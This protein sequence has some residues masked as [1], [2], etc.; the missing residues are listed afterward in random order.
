M[1]YDTITLSALRTRFY[2][3]GEVDSDFVDTTEANAMINLARQD[4]HAFLTS[5]SPDLVQSTQAE[6]IS[7]VANQSTYT[8][9][10]EAWKINGVDVQDGSNWY[11]LDRV[12]WR[13]RNALQNSG[14]DRRSTRYRA[15]GGKITLVPTPS[16]SGTCRVWYVAA[17]ASLSADG[18]TVSIPI[19]GSE[20]YIILHC[21]I[22]YAAKTEDDP[23]LFAAQLNMVKDQIKNLCDPDQENPDYVV[24][25][26]GSRYR[27]ALYGLNL[28]NRGVE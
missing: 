3:R 25:E 13:H 5:L 9:T 6:S 10:E 15:I 27:T 24:D 19:P 21:L 20:D 22:Q 16:W 28:R 4:Y 14:A 1:A 23:Q 17:P 2:D 18:D 7:V 12:S 26:W 11:A 8:L